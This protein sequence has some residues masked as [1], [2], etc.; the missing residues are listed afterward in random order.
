MLLQKNN[1]VLFIWQFSNTLQKSKRMDYFVLKLIKNY[2]QNSNPKSLRYR[3][4]YNVGVFLEDYLIKRNHL[5]T[6]I[7]LKRRN[8][9]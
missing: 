1:S 4:L 5:F 6:C 8:G 7:S 3:W 9:H 2:D